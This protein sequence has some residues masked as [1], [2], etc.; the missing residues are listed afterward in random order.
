MYQQGWSWMRALESGTLSEL[1]IESLQ[2][3]VDEGEVETLADA[4][5]AARL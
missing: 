5:A 1:Q 3:M 2:A 4:A